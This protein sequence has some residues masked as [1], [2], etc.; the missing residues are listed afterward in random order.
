MNIQTSYH[1]TLK[2]VYLL[3]SQPNDRIKSWSYVLE[4]KCSKDISHQKPGLGP[5]LSYKILRDFNAQTAIKC[6]GTSQKRGQNFYQADGLL[7]N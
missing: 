2:S 3:W 1:N 7:K 6:L 5:C 4:F